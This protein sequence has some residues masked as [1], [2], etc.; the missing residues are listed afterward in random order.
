MNRAVRNAGKFLTSLVVMTVICTAAWEVV[1][2][3]LY[4]CRDSVGFDYWQPGN[5]VHGNVVAVQWVSHH[6]SMSELDTIKDGWSVPGLLCL[7]CSFVASSVV[8]SLALALPPWFSN[9]PRPMPA[10]K[11][12]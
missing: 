2:E 3:R 12:C 1:S 6:R 5:W 10:K 7:W 4:D 8:T 9:R 11:A